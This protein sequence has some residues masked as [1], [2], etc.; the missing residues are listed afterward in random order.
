[1]VSDAQGANQ[2]ERRLSSERADCRALAPQIELLIVLA[3]DPE[4]ALEPVPASTEGVR[5][6]ST[7]SLRAAQLGI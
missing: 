2:G 1:V 7:T 4:I 5:R 3:V 6:R